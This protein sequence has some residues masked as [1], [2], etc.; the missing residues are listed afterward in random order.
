MRKCKEAWLIREQV[1]ILVDKCQHSKV[2]CQTDKCLM[3]NNLNQKITSGKLIQMMLVVQ[4]FL[5]H[6][7]KASTLRIRMPETFI[8]TVEEI[9]RKP[10]PYVR[11]KEVQTL[12]KITNHKDKA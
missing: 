9:W 4:V 6:N 11:A 5:I 10:K 2:I 12:M 1:T 7:V 8:S 3:S